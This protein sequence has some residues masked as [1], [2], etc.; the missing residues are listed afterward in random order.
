MRSARDLVLGALSVVTSADEKR[1]ADLLYRQNRDAAEAALKLEVT[2][3]GGNPNGVKLT[4]DAVLRILRQDARDSAASIRQTFRDDL[5]RFA[6][7][8]PEGTNPDDA[9]RLFVEW[10]TRRAV[11]KNRQIAVTESTQAAGLAQRTFIARTKPHGLAWFGHSL[12][13]RICQS[14]AGGN[15]YELTDR[16]VGVIPHPGCRDAWYLEYER[17]GGEVWTG[18]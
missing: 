8:I 12:K 3:A 18:G 4:N 11:W 16:V 1:L 13:C 17:L 6:E 15:P 7:A 14:I 9:A 10:E 5:K 2:N